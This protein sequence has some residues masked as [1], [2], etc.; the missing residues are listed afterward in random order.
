MIYSLIFV[1]IGLLALGLL[2]ALRRG[3]TLYRTPGN[4]AQ[5]L[6]SV[7]ICAFRNLID[8][9]E[10][11]FLRSRLPAPEFRNIQRERLRATAEYILCTAQNAAILLRMGEA[12]RRSSDAAT[13]EAAEK[14][15]DQAVRLRLSAFQALLR[16]E[17]RILF[18]GWRPA[19][20]RVVEG[21]EQVTRQVLR[22]GLQSQPREVSAAS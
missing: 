22:L 6:Q 21:Y 19:S 12:T 8:P 18:P 10:E 16:L 2:F 9:A 3:G 17:L 4:P 13:A 7:D 5:H 20:L 11:D 15:V 1:A 14:L